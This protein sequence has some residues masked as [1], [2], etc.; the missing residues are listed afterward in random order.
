[1]ELYEITGTIDI[2]KSMLIFLI[3]LGLFSSFIFKS[4]SYKNKYIY[5]LFTFSILSLINTYLIKF[6][7]FEFYNFIPSFLLALGPTVLFYIKN[8][9][10][11]QKNVSKKYYPHLAL[12]FFLLAPILFNL[13]SGHE[14]YIT[15]LVLGH[16]GFYLFWSINL[17][18]SKK[19]VVLR[20]NESSNRTANRWFDNFNVI[21]TLS[22]VYITFLVEIFFSQSVIKYRFSIIAI[23]IGVIYLLLRNLILN[24]IKGYYLYRIKNSINNIEKYRDSILSKEKSKELADRMDDFMRSK[25][26]YL[27]EEINLKQLAIDLKTHPKNLSQAINENHNKN[28]FDYINTYRIEDAKKMLKDETF[29]EYKIYEIMYE[30]GFNS[31]SSFNMAFKKNTGITARQYRERNLNTPQNI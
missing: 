2:V 19:I 4:F 10:D 18:V 15:Y 13:F 14:S 30:V 1:M 3:V 25:K 17:L 20:A 24:A 5:L 22:F 27:D 8:A 7:N 12:G 16:F 9:L 31:R 26:T 21:I 6:H 11:N 28:F 29:K 23:A